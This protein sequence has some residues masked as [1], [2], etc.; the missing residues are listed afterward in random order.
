MKLWNASVETVLH[1]AFSFLLGGVLPSKQKRS[2]KVL[3]PFGWQSIGLFFILS[4]VFALFSASFFF[5]CELK[6]LSFELAQKWLSF[7]PN[8]RV[9]QEWEIA[10]KKKTAW[11]RHVQIVSSCCCPYWQTWFGK[12]FP[13]SRCSLQFVKVFQLTMMNI[14]LLDKN[15]WKQ[16]SRI[17]FYCL[18]IKMLSSNACTQ[19]KDS[20][21]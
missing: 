7:G 14:E 4:L 20:A 13:H 21:W 12:L 18:N 6:Q 15:N 5:R 10:Q 1:S 2:V 8:K 3:L 11:L 19:V 9:E 16:S 17:I